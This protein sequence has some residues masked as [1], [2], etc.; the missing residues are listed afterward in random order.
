[1]IKYLGM[2]N[3]WRVAR[4]CWPHFIARPFWISKNLCFISVE[5]VGFVFFFGK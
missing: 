5:F 2:Q 1:M 3:G 4:H